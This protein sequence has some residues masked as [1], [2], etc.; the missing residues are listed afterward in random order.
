MRFIG[1][2]VFLVQIHPPCLARHN[3][4]YT[5]WLHGVYCRST[6]C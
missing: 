5:D 4:S 6:D 3:Q 2:L 1:W